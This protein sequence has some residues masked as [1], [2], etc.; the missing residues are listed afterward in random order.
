MHSNKQRT[1][2]LSV[3]GNW[4]YPVQIRSSQT[5]PGI[6]L[7][8]PSPGAED[9]AGHVT[10]GQHFPQPFVSPAPSHNPALTSMYSIFCVLVILQMPSPLHPEPSLAFQ[11]RLPAVGAPIKFSGALKGVAYPIPLPEKKSL[12]GCRSSYVRGKLISALLANHIMHQVHPLT[13]GHYPLVL[14]D[15]CLP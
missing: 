4:T 12:E 9:S 7:M 11:G 14:C 10:L 8:T 15:C 13:L 3:C 2:W 1:K 6:L 5:D